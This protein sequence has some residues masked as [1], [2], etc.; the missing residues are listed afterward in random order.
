MMP[1]PDR[2][3]RSNP[4][5][6][7]SRVVILNGAGSSGKS[8]IARALQSMTT[9]PFLHVAMDTFLDMLPASQWNHRDGLLFE[10]DAVESDPSIAIR[11][12]PVAEKLLR[13]MRRSVAALAAER[14]NLIVDDVMLGEAKDDYKNLLV[15]FDVS[16]V[17]VFASLAV[18]EE[19]ERLRKDRMLGLARWQFDRVHQGI[20]YDLTVDTSVE[21]P[22]NC[23]NRIKLALKL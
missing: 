4:R 12:G 2:S 1:F 22:E 16:L 13:G 9:E 23:A 21:T 10:L 17:E 7:R 5:S 20:D 11:I 19:R 15:G 3:K 18:L 14:N 6:V 8:S